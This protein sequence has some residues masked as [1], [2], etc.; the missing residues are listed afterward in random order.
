MK[1]NNINFDKIIDYLIDLKLKKQKNK[2][3][4]KF[5]KKEYARFLTNS[6]QEV[7]NV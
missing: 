1:H 4:I 7:K 3:K 2:S 6:R 5:L